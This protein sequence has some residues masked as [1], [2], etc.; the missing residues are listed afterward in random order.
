MGKRAA[1]AEAQTAMGRSAEGSIAARQARPRHRG[2]GG[3]TERVPRRAGARASPS[4]AR[5]GALREKARLNP[6]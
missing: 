2:D 4:K 6:R 5:N 1:S 3:L